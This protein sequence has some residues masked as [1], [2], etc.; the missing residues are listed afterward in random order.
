MG[1]AMS[2]TVIGDVKIQ[3]KIRTAKLVFGRGSVSRQEIA[4]ELG[5]S[6][7]E[8]STDVVTLINA[9]LMEFQ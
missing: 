1:D 3:N 9:S 4:V 5:F 8:V 2:T 7:Q 6:M